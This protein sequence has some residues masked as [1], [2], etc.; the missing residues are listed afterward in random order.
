MNL[1][2]SKSLNQ[3][4]LR[5]VLKGEIRLILNTFSSSF[6]QPLVRFLSHFIFDLGYFLS[7]AYRKAKGS[8]GG[9]NIQENG[10]K[11]RETQT[12]LEFWQK[13]A[14]LRSFLAEI[15]F[16]LWTSP[17]ETRNMGL[18]IFQRFLRECAMI[19]LIPMKNPNQYDIMG[20]KTN[21][22]TNYFH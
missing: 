21:K 13:T 10:N 6:C 18:M 19:E 16:C 7:P 4:F 17:E 15:H 8:S 9:K 14:F 22:Q 5:K 1:K 12:T 11:R 2:K 20:K 3:P